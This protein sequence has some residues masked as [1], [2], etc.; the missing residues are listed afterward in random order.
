MANRPYYSAAA[1]DDSVAVTPSDSADLEMRNGVWPVLYI[2]TA[3]DV[4]HT[5]AAGTT[6]TLALPAGYWLVRTRR[7]FSTATTAAGIIALY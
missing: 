5:T 4:A 6:Q 3:G 7:V 1:A 2:T